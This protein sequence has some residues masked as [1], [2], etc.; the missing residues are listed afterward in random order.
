LYGL[1]FGMPCT[2]LGA[3]KIIKILQSNIMQQWSNFTV[4]LKVSITNQIMPSF[5]T[6]NISL[7]IKLQVDVIIFCPFVH[8]NNNTIIA[9]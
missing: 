2:L 7:I 9:S 1:L 6:C 8:N 5:C 4:T 3:I